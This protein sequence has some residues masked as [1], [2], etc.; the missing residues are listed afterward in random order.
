MDGRTSVKDLHCDKVELELLLGVNYWQRR[1]RRRK[2]RRKRRRRIR[3]RSRG[4]RR[5]AMGQML[6][7]DK[8]QR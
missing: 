4:R 1:R 6:S 8:E 7:D 2:R 5:R 3:R